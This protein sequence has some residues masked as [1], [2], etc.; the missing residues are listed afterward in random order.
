MSGITDKKI[1][2]TRALTELKTLDSRIQKG[3]SSAT[4]VSYCGQFHKPSPQSKNAKQTLQ[5]ITD[6]LERRK[7]IKSRIVMSN[8]VTKVVICGNEMTIAEAIETKSSIKHLQ[9]LLNTMK[10][11]FAEAT[12]SI[13]SINARARRDLDSKTVIGNENDN[14]DIE[15]FSTKFMKMH[16]VDL[17]DPINVQT[18]IERIEN[19]ITEFESQVDFVLTE[20]NSTVY[21]QI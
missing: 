16:G 2:I 14:I 13:E 5:K 7:L 15:E 4:F 18:E 19:Y 6:L 20:K 21:I 9:T 11:Q 8:A 3:I 17:Y 12:R 10:S 1:T